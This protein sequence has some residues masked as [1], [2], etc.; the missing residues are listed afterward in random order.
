[1]VLVLSVVC[2]TL[3]AITLKRYRHYRYTA[4]LNTKRDEIIR[5]EELATVL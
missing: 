4:T 2:I 1:M 5:H 3:V